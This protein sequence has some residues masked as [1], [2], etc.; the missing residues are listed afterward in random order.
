[1]HIVDDEQIGTHEKNRG[2]RQAGKTLWLSS[3]FSSPL[4]FSLQQGKGIIGRPPRI[5][6][7]FSIFLPSA[8]TALVTTQV[9]SSPVV[10]HFDKDTRLFCK[11][12]IKR[13]Q[14]TARKTQLHSATTTQT[15]Y[16]FTAKQERRQDLNNMKFSIV[17]MIGLL[18][19]E[20]TTAFVQKH[21]P[22]TD[23]RHHESSFQTRSSSKSSTTTRYMAMGVDMPPPASSN[24]NLPVIQTNQYGPTNIRY[25]DFLKLVNGD[26]IEKVSFSADGTQ[27]LGVDVNG[28]RVKIDALPNDPELLT[29]LTAHKVRLI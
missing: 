25:S 17:A 4:F 28:G 10:I 5:P 19:A 29:Q 16:Q 6:N 27:L 8:V 24:T 22:M 2:R 23:R 1:M 21:S 18:M 7:S 15:S 11:P 26:R 12:P 20:G 9:V 3:F 14:H 13:K